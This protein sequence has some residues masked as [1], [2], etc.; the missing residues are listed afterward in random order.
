ML[1]D[2]D[3]VLGQEALVAERRGHGATVVE[4]HG[5]G[6][7]ALG[8]GRQQLGPAR[9]VELDELS[10]NGDTSNVRLHERGVAVIERKE[11]VARRRARLLHEAQ[12]ERGLIAT[13]LA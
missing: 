1:G 8:L 5:S 10:R 2:L 7:D 9:V 4:L 11:P 13:D 12:A 3:A 6:V